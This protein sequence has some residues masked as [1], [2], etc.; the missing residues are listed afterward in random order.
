VIAAGAV[1]MGYAGRQIVRAR[2]V[3]KD[4]ALPA[5]TDPAPPFPQGIEGKVPG[6]A[7]FRTPND[8]FYRIDTRLTLPVIDVDSWTLTI[9]GDV[10]TEVT[11]T[12]DDLLTMPLIERDLCQRHPVHGCAAG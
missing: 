5:T 11:F 2:G 12:F 7:P 1:A 3:I 9:D 8:E 10:E 6:V 4:L